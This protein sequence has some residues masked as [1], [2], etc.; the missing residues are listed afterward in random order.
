MWF[1]A[2]WKLFFFFFSSVFF[3]LSKYQKGCRYTKHFTGRERERLFSSLTYNGNKLTTI[4]QSPPN[5]AW[6]NLHRKTVPQIHTLTLRRTRQTLWPWHCEFIC[7]RSR[8]SRAKVN[9]TSLI[10][11]EV[12]LSLNRRLHLNL[13]TK[14]LT[15]G[16]FQDWRL[17]L[18]ASFEFFQG[19]KEDWSLKFPVSPSSVT[20]GVRLVPALW[21]CSW[22]ALDCGC[23]D[24][25]F[26]VSRL[27]RRRLR[28]RH[29]R[30][31]WRTRF[32]ASSS[33]VEWFHL[34]TSKTNKL[35]FF[36]FALPLT[37]LEALYSLAQKSELTQF[38]HAAAQPAV[39]AQ[40]P[41]IELV[42]VV[43]AEL[44]LD[45]CQHH[46]QVP[47]FLFELGYEGGVSLV[48]LQHGNQRLQLF[49]LV[50]QLLRRGQRKIKYYREMVKSE[51][52]SRK[53][54]LRSTAGGMNGIILALAEAPKY[55]DFVGKEL[56]C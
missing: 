34:W 48:L 39:Q 5:S 51:T 50:F 46:R 24:V 4:Q 25:C 43:G 14:G 28:S 47:D 45:A 16:I 27:R 9:W 31:Q 52:K 8:R 38:A 37:V 40:N 15:K 44:L 23:F 53:L 29:A 41:L 22:L 10:V 56:C 55:E 18:N 26:F 19:A 32:Y 12:P 2:F 30:R 20:F 17:P 21:M 7:A 11:G 1:C 35:P 6:I 36:W 54:W 33:E 49:H 3:F 42:V 13:N